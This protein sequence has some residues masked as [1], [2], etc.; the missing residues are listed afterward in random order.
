MVKF[1]L[2]YKNI[3]GFAKYECLIC[4]HIF[5]VPKYRK[6]EKFIF[7]IYCGEGEYKNG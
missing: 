7:C 6:N 2:L 3:T 4:N 1:K 5:A